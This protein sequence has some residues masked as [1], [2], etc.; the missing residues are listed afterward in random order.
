VSNSGKTE[1]YE[2]VSQLEYSLEEIYTDSDD[3][4]FLKK[5][6]ESGRVQD[7]LVVRQ[8]DKL[9]YAY[10]ENQI[11]TDLL[12]KM[13][14]LST[15]IQKKFSTFRGEIDDDKVTDN[16]IKEILKTDLDSVYRRKAWLAS[17]QVGKVV[18]NDLVR[19]VKLRNDAARKVGFANYHRLSL[20]TAEQDVKELDKIFDE[21]YELTNEPYARVKGELDEILAA[22]YG[23]ELTEL[24][25][26]HYHDPFFQETPLVYEINLDA[27]YKGKNVKELA[28]RFYVGIGLQVDEI[29]AKSDLYEREG[30]NPH[31]FCTDIDRE[32]DVRILCN[33]KDTEQWM[34]T[35]LHELGHGVYGKYH[36]SQV[37]YLLR[38]PAHIF[39]TEAIAMFFGRLSRHPLWMQQMLDLSNEERMQ[40][41]TVSERYA[42]LKQLIFVR[43]AMVM[44]QF[45]KELYRDPD[46]DLNTL[47]WDMV[48]KYQLIRRPERRN[49]P[50]WAAKIH[51]TIAPVYYHNYMLGELLA[52]QLHNYIVTNVMNVGSDAEVSY[53][54][55]GEV[56]SYLR[57]NVFEA[58]SVY[59]WNDMIERATDEKLT[60][61]YFVAQFVK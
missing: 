20:A 17:K 58:G 50:D 44:Y 6:K 1:D 15:E 32:G 48:Q 30:K 51:F 23:V 21:L 27:Y 24:G 42:Q 59:Y 10:L 47:W 37:P 38:E 12:K 7:A 43:W 16:Q 14:D 45:E 53:V 4:D 56:G 36:N 34:E 40:I 3:Y 28:E 61:K 41:E 35:M 33:L 39:T 22:K 46:Q 54:G 19:L 8:L 31:A 26:W 55:A 9:Y 25:P 5:M 29:L 11:D 60:A 57:E 18:A 2:K 13:V 52:S 49:E